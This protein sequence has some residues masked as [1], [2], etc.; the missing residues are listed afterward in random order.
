[1][2]QSCNKFLINDNFYFNLIMVKEILVAED[3]GKCPNSIV[4]LTN[5][6]VLSK[7]YAEPPTITVAENVT[8]IFDGGC[9][10]GNFKLVG[11]KTSI[12]APITQIFDGVTVDGSWI[13]DRAY[14][15]WFDAKVGKQPWFT[16]I[17][18]DT[19]QLVEPY[20]CS[21]AINSAI[22][23][24][25]IGEVFLPMG[26]YYV[27]HKIVMTHGIQLIG[28]GCGRFEEDA[29]PSHDLDK[30]GY[31]TR[32]V[33]FV[34]QTGTDCFPDGAILE[35]NIKRGDTQSSS[36]GK[37]TWSRHHPDP[38]STISGIMFSNDYY[39]I[40]KG[41]DARLTLSGK[42]CCLVAGGFLFENVYWNDFRCAI[43][44]TEDY[45]DIKTTRHCV[46]SSD[47]DR[48]QANQSGLLPIQFKGKSY[49]IDLGYSGDALVFENC[50]VHTPPKR[51]SESDGA[52]RLNSCK[53]GSI[54]NNIFN[55]DVRL[56]GVRNLVFSGNHMEVGAQLRVENCDIAINNNH[57]ERGRRPSVVFDV[58]DWSHGTSVSSPQNSQFSVVSMSG[59][60]FFI[61][62]KAVAE[63]DLLGR[64]GIKD[65]SNYDVALCNLA[66][67][68]YEL[69][70]SQNYRYVYMADVD[71]PDLSN[72]PTGISIGQYETPSGAV[73]SVDEFNKYSHF[74]STDA[75][76][77]PLLGI[78]KRKVYSSIPVLSAKIQSNEHVLNLDDSADGV[79]ALV[80][81]WKY[82]YYGEVIID[83]VRD[84]RG[85]KFDFTHLT[86][87]SQHGNIIVLSRQSGGTS[88]MLRITRV[89]A[90][91]TE[92]YVDVP[93]CGCVVLYDNYYCVNGY[94]WQDKPV[95]ADADSSPATMVEFKNRNVVCEKSSVPVSNTGWVK[96]DIIVNNGDTSSASMWYYTG[97]KWIAR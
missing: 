88:C 46:F 91:G 63:S 80:S 53:G 18:D 41:Y 25:K 76:I 3:L 33:P 40:V 50:A 15:Q 17:V 74:L 65:I 2:N 48:V 37:V 20:D 35:L 59:N 38:T 83:P 23:M 36:T 12:Q 8:L 45:A 54:S 95:V 56:R 47:L 77:Q 57:F 6:V 62:Y 42:V 81:G 79:P 85:P 75:T 73:S 60:T 52:L 13:C 71:S 64:P 43:K 97:S 58:E 96:G 86:Y 1:M 94:K 19:N 16:S 87:D 61:W 66:K 39:R 68:P 9:I 10:S 28:E 5:K 84:I 55:R 82:S 22:A 67:S 92:Q 27:S 89:R 30:W 4:R 34:E 51:E 49:I 7:S 11:N 69:H 31:A 29:V 44:V 70:L 72:H 32:I 24:K 93:L 26:F 78:E 21:V 14:P 90:S